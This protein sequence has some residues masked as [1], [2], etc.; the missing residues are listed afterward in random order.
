VGPNCPGETN[1]ATHQQITIIE[2]PLDA[3]ELAVA[4]PH[5]IHEDTL[6]TSLVPNAVRGCHDVQVFLKLN[7]A[8]ASCNGEA[9]LWDISDPGN[10]CTIDAACHTHVRNPA[11][12][13]WHSAA[14]TWD[15]Q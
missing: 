7:I 8:A 13:F 10:P 2:V 4:R 14:F 5:P 6:T 9:Q 3:P 15:G 12:V 11:L 1:R